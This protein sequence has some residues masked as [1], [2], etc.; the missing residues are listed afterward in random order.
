MSKKKLLGL[1]GLK[2]NPFSPDI[3]I[4]AVRLTD[5]VERFCWRVEELSLDGG[6]AMITGDPG[7]GKSVVLRLLERRLGDIR[8]VTVCSLSRPQSSVAD[9]YR[10]LGESFGSTISASNRWGGFKLLREKWKA[11]LESSLRR[12]VILI[13]E[14]QEMLPAVLSELRLLSS[15]R[16]DSQSL[17]TVVLAGDARLTEKFRHD[18]LL[19]LGSRIRTRLLMEPLAADELLECLEHAVTQAGNAKL[20]T[21]ELMVTLAEHSMGNWRAAMIMAHE[22]LM[23]A[24]A[25]E[26][27]ELDEKLFFDLYNKPPKPRARSARGKVGSTR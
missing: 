12:P 22:L 27:A 20:M 5:R 7:T 17:L 23:A 9:F 14:A 8:D 21:R 4:E 18:D 11:K 3:P 15:D 26:R 16:F 25:E 19:P 1:Y 10:E 6:F 2:W 13:D 24:L